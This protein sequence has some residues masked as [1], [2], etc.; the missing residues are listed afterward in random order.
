M[1][2]SSD[3]ALYEN[4]YWKE[5]KSESK[6]RNNQH[7]KIKTIHPINNDIIDLILYYLIIIMMN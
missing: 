2:N 5:Y 6:L 4:K 7:E 1:F 3:P